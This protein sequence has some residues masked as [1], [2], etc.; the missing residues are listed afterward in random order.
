VVAYVKSST[1]AKRGKLRTGK[2]KGQ[3]AP[4]RVEKAVFRGGEKG[5]R[6]PTPQV[7][8]KRYSKGLN[9]FAREQK[10]K[11]KK[12]GRGKKKKKAG[13]RHRGGTK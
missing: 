5:G 4:Q 2:G 8:E 11:K 10:E 1:H 3:G 7:Y 12:Q 13:G 6:S 9:A